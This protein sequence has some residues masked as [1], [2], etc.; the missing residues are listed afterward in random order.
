ME[1]ILELKNLSVARGG[2]K[3]FSGIT[4]SIPSGCNTAILGPNGAGKSTFLKL[5]TRE[6]YPIP[7]AGSSLEIFGEKLWNIWELRSRIG[8][9]SNDLQYM[10][11]A[12]TLGNDVVRSGFFA[13]IGMW[14]DRRTT[15]EQER[16]AKKILRELGIEKLAKREFGSC[17]TGEQRRLILARALV[18]KPSALI[19]D[20]PTSGLDLRA[21]ILYVEF[22]RKLMREGTTV[23]L[24]THNI[25]EIPPEIRRVILIKSGTIAGDGVPEK[26]LTSKSLSALFEIPLSI[27]QN[28]GFFQAAPA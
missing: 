18:S 16:D 10:F 15:P 27:A 26:M 3:I 4:L 25:G 20:E 11:P 17:S 8:I 14:K 5:L 6:I 21:A 2:K 24:V 12:E 28:N 1:N 22:L 19:L 9:V 13:S 7:A 23:I